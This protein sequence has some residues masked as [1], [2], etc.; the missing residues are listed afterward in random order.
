MIK[1]SQDSRGKNAPTIF[2]FKKAQQTDLFFAI[3]I[4]AILLV[5]GT[6]VPFVNS[7]FATTGA[8]FSTS[9]VETQLLDEDIE[10][11]SSVKPLDVLKSIGKMFFWTFGDVPLALDLILLVLRIALLIILINKFVPFLG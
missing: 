10:D 3:M 1:L 4:V 7:E 8:N 11:I 6:L 5:A 9:Q 2:K